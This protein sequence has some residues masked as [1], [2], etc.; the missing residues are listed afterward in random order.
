MWKRAELNNNWV[1]DL[2]LYAKW[3]ARNVAHIKDENNKWQLALTYVKNE[4]NEWC[5]AITY[6][7]DDNNDWK[8][9]IK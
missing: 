2:T 1:N 4:K 9:S 5:P 8:Q 7:K 3:K 6:I